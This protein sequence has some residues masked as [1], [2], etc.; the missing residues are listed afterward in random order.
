I[1]DIAKAVQSFS[2][3]FL[4]EID[5][6]FRPSE[7]IVSPAGTP[8]KFL[9]HEYFLTQA[10]DQIQ[11]NLLA[12]LGETTGL[13]WFSLTGK[14]GTGK[15]LLL[16]DIGRSLAEEA[17]TAILHWGDLA[18]GHRI[19]NAAKTGLTIL[20]WEVMDGSEDCLT[21]LAPYSYLL[22]DES[23]RLTPQQFEIICGTARTCRQRVVFCLDPEQILTTAE[24]K[25]DIAGRIE[26]L[27]PAESFTLSEHLRGNRQLQSFI[28]EV[29]D[30]NSKPKAPIAYT[31]VDLGFARTIGEARSQLAYY[32]DKGYIFINYYRSARRQPAASANVPV[33]PFAEFEGG[34]DIHH[35]IGQ[36]F[37]RVVLLLDNSFHYSEDGKLE[38]IPSPDPDFLYPNL[39]YQSVT[40]VQEKLALIVLENEPLFDAIA[41][42]LR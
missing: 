27:P 30:L 5:G 26:G 23:H 19:I 11:K 17:R 40:R 9:Q 32:R 25:N 7:Y 4:S 13:A 37:D 33:N 8:E 41:E 2:G 6:L 31:D 34:F 35:V 16:Y 20:P 39:F 28:Q 1:T 22:V 3:D 14:P 38:G 29:R 21:A 42:I 36:E 10:Q 18:E 15:T 24:R 12:A